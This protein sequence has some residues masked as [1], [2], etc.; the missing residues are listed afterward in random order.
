MFFS[1]KSLKR[2]VIM[3]KQGKASTLDQAQH[4]SMLQFLSNSRHSERNKAIYLLTYRAGLRIGS[5]AGLR[6]N[7]VIDS[8]GKLKEVVNL[9]SSIVK[10]GKNYAAYINHPELRAA[11]VDFLRIRRDRKGVDALFMS[12]KG[13]A[14]TPNSLSHLM[15]KLYGSA[16]FEQASSHSGRR[17]FAT[18]ILRSGVDIVALKTLMNH[19]NIATTAEYVSHNEEYLKQAILGA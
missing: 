2:M 13:T 16:G 4:S 15:L 1:P 8:S 9:H 19:S 12:Q 5:V 7:D 6:L 18:N 17:S 3:S 14:F 11:L 10:G